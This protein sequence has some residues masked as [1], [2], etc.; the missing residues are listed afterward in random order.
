MLTDEQITSHYIYRDSDLEKVPASRI[1]EGDL[2]AS[3]GPVGAHIYAGNRVTLA[4]WSG[5]DSTGD[6]YRI[7]YYTPWGPLYIG[8]PESI[9]VWRVRA[10]ARKGR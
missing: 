5:H 7:E 1:R 6:T 4:S 8:Q 3:A 10:D 9:P 2:L